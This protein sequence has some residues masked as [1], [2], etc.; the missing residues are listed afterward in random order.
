MAKPSTIPPGFPSLDSLDSAPKPRP[1]PKPKP[2]RGP[3]GGFKKRLL[4]QLMRNKG[5]FASIVFPLGLIISFGV[6]PTARDWELGALGYGLIPV[7]AWITAFAVTLRH[8]RIWIKGYWQY[9]LG[10]AL[11]V[12]VSLGILSMIDATDGVMLDASLGG[13]WGG[14][15]GGHPLWLGAVKIA[16]ILLISPLLLVPRE[17]APLYK[18][19]GDKSLNAARLASVWTGRHLK[20]LFKYLVSHRPSISISRSRSSEVAQDLPEFAS[21]PSP[22]SQAR[23][24][25]TGDLMPPEPFG[26]VEEPPSDPR[27]KLGKG[28]R[29]SRGWQLPSPELLSVGESRPMPQNVLEQMARHIEETLAEHRVE[30][31]V[32]DIRTGPRV[33]RFGLVPGWVK[34]YRESRGD[35]KEKDEPGAEMS[36]VKVQ[37]ILVREKDLALALKTPYLRL[38]APVPGEALVGL[39]VPNPYPRTVALRSVTESS[40]FQK[41]AAAGGLPVALG[42]DTGGSP[43]A[44]DLSELPHLLIAGATGSGKSVCI[45]AVIASLLLTCSPELVRLLMVDPKR[46]ELTPFNGIPHLIAPVIVDTDEVLVVLRAIQN[47]MLRRYKLMEEMGVRN[48]VGYNKKA[49][50]RLPYLVIVIDELADLMMAAAYEVEQSLVRL[51]Q[52]GRATGIHLILATQRPSV[53]V[54]TGLLKA[55][56]PARIAFVVA[57]QVDSRVILDSVGAE[58]LLGKGDTLLLTSDSPKPKRVQGT[59]V[60]DTDIEKLVEFWKAQSGPPLPEIPLDE[61]AYAEPGDDDEDD[62]ELLE[63]A[64]EV[65]ER[66]SSVTPS[67]LQ[68]RLQIGY[69]RALRLVHAMEEEGLIPAFSESGSFTGSGTVR[70]LTED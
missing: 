6:W 8:R 63:R 46:V 42:E 62:P 31:A 22:A 16:A 25:K 41:I 40:A 36:R 58:K 47:Q 70:N 4:W 26:E 59:F 51:A 68:R 3:K 38:E 60:D 56:I 55:N 9:W 66:S 18:R 24:P 28:K 2:S 11:A 19:A 35:S 50:E 27:R 29:G 57:S 32:D 34:K 5:Y 15:L 30:V 43:V 64:R 65:A 53:N 10:S 44:A 13:Y 33:L 12:T 49:P 48:I 45:N 21:E 17:A 20:L 37:S 61:D 39:E 1:K 69:P 7:A 67:L 52:L 54:V 23:K 14:Y